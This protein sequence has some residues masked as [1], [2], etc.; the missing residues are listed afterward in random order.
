MV[1]NV[2]GLWRLARTVNDA[3]Y[4]TG[5]TQAAAR[6]RTLSVTLGS[7]NFDVIHFFLQINKKTARDQAVLIRRQSYTWPSDENQLIT[8]ILSLCHPL[9]ITPRTTN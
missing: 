5:M 4:T 1:S 9:F 3:R 8:A 7:V 6:T 2:Y